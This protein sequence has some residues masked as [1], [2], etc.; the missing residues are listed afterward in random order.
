M[1]GCERLISKPLPLPTQKR[2]LF[3][4]LLL[5]LVFPF[6]LTPFMNLNPTTSNIFSRKE[7][8]HS[9]KQPKFP[10]R[11]DPSTSKTNKKDHKRKASANSP[12]NTTTEQKTHDPI[13][14][15]KEDPPR[16]Q[17][18]SF[19]P[20]IYFNNPTNHTTYFKTRINI[21]VTVRF[22]QG[23][24]VTNVTAEVNNTENVTLVNTSDPTPIS[25][26][27]YYN[28]TWFND[29]YHFVD[30]NN[31][32]TVYAKN[33]DGN[34]NSSSVFFSVNT[35]SPRVE[36]YAPAN[37]SMVSGNMSIQ[38]YWNDS[39]PNKVFIFDND[40]LRNTT[41]NTGNL[42]FTWDTSQLVGGNHTLTVFANDTTGHVNRTSIWVY[43]DNTVPSVKIRSP[44]NNSYSSHRLFINVTAY[45]VTSSIDFVKAELD[46]EENISLVWDHSNL[47]YNKTEFTEGVHHLHIFVA[48]I[49]GN[50]NT[51]QTV[52][53]TVGIPCVRIRFSFNESVVARSTEIEVSWRDR[54]PETAILYLNGTKNHS[55]TDD[56]SWN[57]T[58][59]TT[60]FE[61]GV[62]NL[63]F[64][65]N[66]THGQ[67]NRTFLF[68]EVDNSKP[69]ITIMQPNNNSYVSGTVPIQFNCSDAHFVS[70]VL[71]LSNS[72]LDTWN[73]LG[74]HT[75]QWNTSNFEDER[76]CITLH[77]TDGVNNMAKLSLYY[78]I[79]NLNPNVSIRYPSN[80]TVCE[81]ETVTINVSVTD[82]CSIK[83]VR[84]VLNGE[85][86]ISLQGS[87]D[88]IYSFTFQNLL[89]ASH[90]VRIYAVDTAGNVN[91]ET[92]TTF[93]VDTLPPSLSIT[94]PDS[95]SEVRSHIVVIQW[96]AQDNVTGVNHCE[97]RINKE[98]WIVVED[99]SKYSFYNI[100]DGS[101]LI[102][103][104]AIDATGK[105]TIKSITFTVNASPI[106]GP[107]LLEESIL[108]GLL[109]AGVSGASYIV[110]QRNKGK[111]LKDLSKEDYHFFVVLEGGV[112]I[113]SYPKLATEEENLIS[114]LLGALT[115]LGDHMWGE[116]GIT[117]VEKEG[118]SI[119]AYKKDKVYFSLI[120][121]TKFDIETVKKELNQ[122]ISKFTTQVGG[123][124]EE[125]EIPDNTKQKQF[126]QWFKE[127]FN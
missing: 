96:E 14:S 115:S 39:N 28:Q 67:E 103:V 57:V 121:E 24:K 98:K 27:D 40:T 35:S 1:S 100:K 80:Y 123:T 48:D 54:N 59:N 58:W 56:G 15:P 11:P 70:V 10:E 25:D 46:G 71:S 117:K 113:Y 6:F 63:T 91:N 125:L 34:I 42:T 87:K 29:T 94:Q 60:N 20:D 114:F 4:F 32:I 5:L 52:D 111:S 102:E 97:V 44:L 90:W 124:P 78:T 69:I 22:K 88:S 55:W 68:L 9:S 8:G 17:A 101:H 37:N 19:Y 30:G 16:L 62:Y 89:D 50:V 120:I 118:K 23:K 122:I 116:E 26:T 72:E 126:T 49:V 38:L 51:T 99:Q 65:A 127:T 31:N 93:L 95:N 110:Y 21:N 3:T 86:T 79:D 81:T 53:F 105:T 7:S 104:K 77:A 82:N 109:I 119:L 73:T 84:A 33:K 112:P 47:Y 74:T 13:P 36:L 108:V 107:G 66:D 61:D 2:V 45:D 83:T 106:G 75:Y 92:M 18:T 12:T 76:V 85:H 64:W 41:N 43:M